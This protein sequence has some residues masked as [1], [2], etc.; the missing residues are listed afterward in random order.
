MNSCGSE[1]V[2]GER[3]S[4]LMKNIAAFYAKMVVNASQGQIIPSNPK[5]PGTPIYRIQSEN[6]AMNLSIS[7][8]NCNIK[9]DS[10]LANQVSG[11]V[12]GANTYV[13][14]IGSVNDVPTIG[15]GAKYTKM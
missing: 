1:D 8:L 11:F 5:T 13:F 10:S 15:G 12:S 9:K 2:S 7:F 4:I 3:L 6:T 14:D